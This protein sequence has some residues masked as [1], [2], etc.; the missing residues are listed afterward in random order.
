MGNCL[1]GESDQDDD[2]SLLRSEVVDDEENDM[3]ASAPQPVHR[4]SVNEQ[5]SKLIE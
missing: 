4:M 5:V 3:S 1:K 2:V